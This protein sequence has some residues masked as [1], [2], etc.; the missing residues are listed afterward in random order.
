VDGLV[1]DGNVEI[2]KKKVFGLAALPPRGAR[3]CSSSLVMPAPALR[4]TDDM[5]QES[6]K[7]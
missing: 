5:T 6:V 7:A 2:G 3:L 4:T 1:E